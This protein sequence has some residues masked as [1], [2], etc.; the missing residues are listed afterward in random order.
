MACNG[1]FATPDE[2]QA[3]WFFDF[4]QS[5]G[6]EL[7]PLLRSSAGRIH[8]AMAASGQCDCDLAGWADDYLKELNMTAAAVMFNIA[9]VRL[10]NE[11]RTLFMDYLTDQLQLIRNGEIEL[12]DGET[13]RQ[14]PA[15]GV[16][17]IA[18]TDR[19]AAEIIDRRRQMEGS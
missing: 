17:Q 7:A 11:Q 14:Y 2:F 15:F 6:T 4:T 1:A 19:T 18:L 3:Q 16:A 12:C 9:C 8:A 10:S 13:A 5:E